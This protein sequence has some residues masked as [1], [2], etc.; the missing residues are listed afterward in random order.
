GG[1]GEYNFSNI[2]AGNYKVVI[3]EEVKNTGDGVEGNTSWSGGW[4]FASEQI[5]T[6]QN[7][8]L[9]T[10]ID[11]ELSFTLEGHLSDVNFGIQLPPTA[12][13]STYTLNTTPAGGTTIDLDGSLNAQ[14]GPVEGTEQSDADGSVVTV[15]IE[16]LLETDVPQVGNEPQLYYDG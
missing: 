15:I 8:G 2:P 4:E 10:D 3:S 6:T 9:D 16:S 7:V 12:H 1:T 14:E 13:P 5:G 11:A